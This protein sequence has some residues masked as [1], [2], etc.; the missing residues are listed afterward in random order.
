MLSCCLHV[1]GIQLI[2]GEWTD[3]CLDRTEVLHCYGVDFLSNKEV[4]CEDVS[5]NMMDAKSS[6]H[7][8]F[9]ET[10]PILHGIFLLNVSE[11]QSMNGNCCK[12]L[13]SHWHE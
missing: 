11:Y 4:V 8:D 12:C 3:D 2:L 13:I 9:S 1:S 10:K 5:S 7:Q 6:R